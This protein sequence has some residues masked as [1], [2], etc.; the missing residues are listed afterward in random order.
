MGSCIPSNTGYGGPA[1]DQ[2]V[3]MGRY[4]SMRE[5]QWV[6][7][8]VVRVQLISM[9]STKSSESR[10]PDSRYPPET[11]PTSDHCFVS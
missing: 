11:I 5:L 2:I 4:V 7:R 9:Q 10:T 1:R 3:R 8:L 6:F